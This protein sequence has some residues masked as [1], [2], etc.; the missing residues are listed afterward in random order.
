[1]P[2]VQKSADAQRSLDYHGHLEDPLQNYTSYV[3]NDHYKMI[4][5]WS[6]ALEG[7]VLYF[8]TQSVRIGQVYGFLEMLDGL[9]Q[10][11][12]PQKV[13]DYMFKHDL[14]QL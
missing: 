14:R 8:D 2:G 3:L 1:M 9:R 11:E 4:V 5:H 7:A 13:S 10:W 12:I 6:L